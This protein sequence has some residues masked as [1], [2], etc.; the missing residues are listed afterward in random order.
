MWHATCMQVNQCNS[1]LLMVRSQIGSLIPNLSFGHNLCFKYANGSCE[2]ILNIYISRAFQW[3]KEIFNPM[4]FDPCN[5][6]LKIRESI[7]T[8]TPKVGAHLG[9]CEFIPS[10]S[11]TPR[12]M[13]CDSRASLLPHTFVSL[14]L[15]RKPKARVTTS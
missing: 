3:Y 6:S 10:L 11:Y 5:F 13:K 14:C 4:S 7:E 8:P 15:G 1:Q 12:S 9:V 2:P